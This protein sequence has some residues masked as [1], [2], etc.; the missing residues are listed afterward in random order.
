MPS[1]KPLHPVLLG[2]ALVMQV[3]ASA[4]PASTSRISSRSSAAIIWQLSGIALP[5]IRCRAVVTILLEDGRS[6]HRSAS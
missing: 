1:N 4:L 3:G 2:L 6:R 5:A